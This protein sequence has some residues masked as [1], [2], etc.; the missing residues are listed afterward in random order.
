M[1]SC[2]HT[3]HTE[4]YTKLEKAEASEGEM[5]VLVG[6]LRFARVCVAWDE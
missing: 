2:L 3:A 6:R 5:L 4:P 1:V